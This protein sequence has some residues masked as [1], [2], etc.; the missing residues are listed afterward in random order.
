MLKHAEL[1]QTEI[2]AQAAALSASK[3]VSALSVAIAI[4]I[5]VHAVLLTI[6]FEPELKKLANKLPSLNVVLV[7]AKTKNAPDKAELLAQANLDRGG[8]TDA[9]RQMKTALPAPKQKN[10]EVKLRPSAEANSAAK[11]AK[12]KAQ[13][14]REQKRV[15]ALEKQAQ[16]LL[17]QINSVKKVESNPTQDAASADPEQGDQKAFAKT[18][19]RADLIAASIEIDR[20]EAQIAKQ[21][22]EYQ[23]R[24]KRRFIGARTK[25]ASDAMY[26]E[27]WRQKV[28]RIGNLNYPTVAKDQKIYGQ[29][30]M[31]VSIKAD[32]SIE[33]IVID[34]SSG[35][36]ILDEAAKN[37]VNLAAPYAKF[38]EEMKKNTDILGITRTWTFTQED[39]LATQ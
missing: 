13:E 32:G 5:I 2:A 25:E 10:T 11:A 6:H 12:L 30:R 15:D 24:P 35:S 1:K 7:N 16:E 19:N 17:T 20:L 27:A 28:E 36:K 23:K 26:L 33:N 3:T 18:L 38:S 14:A 4:S 22:D 8:N 9:N 29:L 37:I 31:T 39:A 21:K 34:K